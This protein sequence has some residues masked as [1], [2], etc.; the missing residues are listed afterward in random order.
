[1]KHVQKLLPG[2][3]FTAL[4]AWFAMYVQTVPMV[5]M[6]HLSSLILAILLGMVINNLVKLPGFLS[7]GIRFSAKKILRLAIILLGFKLSFADVLQ[8]GGK[9]LIAVT[10]VTAATMLFT[11]WL[12][13]RMGLDEK[14]T[15]L[16]G[17]GTS[18][19]GASAIAAVAPVV[20]AEEKDTSFAIAAITLFGTLS[21]FVYPILYKL[22]HIPEMLYSIWAGASIHEVAQVVAAGFAAGEGAGEFATLVKL[23]RVLLVIP[24]TLILG[25]REARKTV[26]EAHEGNDVL[27]GAMLE[28]ANNG[29]AG[30]SEQK[31][32]RGK[33][34]IPWFV[35]GFLAMVIV[36]S[37][38]ILPTTT[39]QGIVKF[40]GFLLTWSMV[41]LGLE[42]SLEKM[43]KVGL[44]PFYAG[45]VVTVFIAILGFLLA[46]IVY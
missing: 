41:G 44:K 15:M 10:V 7:D 39:V 31:A 26:D 24:I 25:W 22:F 34:V 1:M 16:I 14:L 43:K 4:L 32:G 23:A 35:F 29:M 33:M 5:E 20:K 30:R 17:A 38:G 46:N 2:L 11:I 6:L 37:V 13:K 45:F 12:G 42:T 28:R 19:C 40:D 27:S 9:G 18:I 3:I 36:N 21:M 8:I